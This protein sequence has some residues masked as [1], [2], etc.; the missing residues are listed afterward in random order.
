[1]SQVCRKCGYERQSSDTTPKAE[2]PKCGAIYAKVD[3]HLERQKA[4][5]AKRQEAEEQRQQQLQAK[6]DETKQRE[7]LQKQVIVKT[8][9]GS[10]AKAMELFQSDAAKMAAEGY[11]PTSQSWAPGAYGCGSFL[12]ALLLCVVLV[13][14]LIF[15]YMHLVKPDGTLTVSYQ[16]SE[17]AVASNSVPSAEK[18][19]PKCAEQVKAAAQVCRFCGHNFT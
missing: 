14:F 6:L 7:R 15:I 10:Q 1:M 2:C 17:A 5:A 3:E 8:Y 19:C 4:E 11:F 18:T 13:G 12:G 16:R 9:K